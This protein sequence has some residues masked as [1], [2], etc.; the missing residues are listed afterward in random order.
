MNESNIFSSHNRK[1]KIKTFS[2]QKER[3]CQ[4]NVEVILIQILGMILSGN[5]RWTFN[6]SPP[7]LDRT[8]EEIPGPA[9]SKDKV[10]LSLPQS[11]LA[12][13]D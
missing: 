1:N 2:P 3:A 5:K 6:S 8:M 11:T 4:Q 7:T 12:F 9:V 13:L 10:D